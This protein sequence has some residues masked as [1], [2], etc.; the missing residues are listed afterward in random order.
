MRANV[1][2]DLAQ[3]KSLAFFDANSIYWQIRYESSSTGVPNRVIVCY[4]DS[5]TD[6]LSSTQPSLTTVRFRDP[7]VNNPENALLGAMYESYF[8]YSTT[9]PWIVQNANSW[10][11]AGTGLNNGDSIPGVVGYEYDKV[12]NNGL[13]PAG[14]TVL[15][16]SPILDI[17]GNHSF[18]NSTVYTAASGGIV[19]DASTVF[20][21]WKLES[22]DYI[23]V[24]VDARIQT[25]TKN[26]LNAMI[27]A[28]TSPTPTP[29]AT[30][31][32]TPTPTPT[33]TATSTPTPTPT[34]T[35]T[36]TPTPTP[37]ATATSTPTPTPT[38]TSTSTPTPTPTATPAYLNTILADS[39]L[40]Y[41]RLGEPAGSTQ[42]VD[43][44]GH[45]YTA[46]YSS[47]GITY[48]VPGA[49]T[50]DTNTAIG[51]AGTG[52]VSPPT[53]PA[54]TNFTIEGWT[55]LTDA[56]W[57]SGSSYN[58]GLYGSYNKVRLLIRPNTSTTNQYSLGYFGVWLSGVEYA[59]Q[60]SLKTVSNTGQWVY[61]AMVRNG[62]TLTVYRN[63]VQVGQRTDLPA[64]ATANIN[65]QILAM[66]SSYFLKGNI[67]E[68]AVYNTALS[69]TQVLAHYNA[70]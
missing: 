13:T 20:W 30:A 17:Y 62:A 4:K 47:S 9:F 31:T 55:Y 22:N 66:D 1:T 24:G 39:P 26:I 5:S 58:N 8:D 57:D 46:T 21:S 50:T 59:L 10:V 6:P 19:F 69:A 32:S 70:H 7:P 16:N 68:V 29:T 33:A 65:G 63:G 54:V 2:A 35:A 48:G 61:W 44:S 40:A 25:I 27:N 53:L 41:W 34:A 11:Y 52:K 38:A 43:T 42:A 60:P 15:S 23:T 67:D 64:T 14:V 51:S 36:S 12:Y 56:T 49:L 18:A 3:G 45:N 28:G 37:T